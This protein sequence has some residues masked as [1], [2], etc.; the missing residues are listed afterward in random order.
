MNPRAY[1]TTAALLA[2][3]GFVLVAAL[4]L[5]VDA[6]G[7]FGTRLIS[8]AHFPSNLRLMRGWDRV[9]KAI[10]IAERR[11]DQVLFIG[12]SRSQLGIDPDSPALSGMRAY[13]A[14]LAGATLTE[15]IVA[16]D[17]SLAHDPGIKH[18]VWGLSFE[19]F[20]FGIFSWSDYPDSA[21]AGRGMIAGLMR[22]LFAYD[23]VI[24]SW[25]TLLQ[26]RRQVRAQMK[27]N[28]VVTYS[29]ETLEGPAV[30]KMFDSEL[31]GM[32]RNISGKRPQEA[33]DEAH[34]KLKRELSELKSAGVD[35][36]LV[37]MPL[38][39]WR[40]EFFRQIDIEDQSD[41]WKRR[42]AATL[43]ELASAPGSGKLRVFDFAR[44]HP[45]VEQSIFAPPPPG[46]R[47]YY[48]ESSHF[49][50][51]LGEKL[52]ETVFAREQDTGAEPTTEPFGRQIG[53]RAGAISID[54][55]LATAKAALDD[56]EAAHR[57]DVSHV[58]TLIMR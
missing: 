43:D 45:L 39:V 19:E 33:M 22:H 37:I 30:L 35:V 48:L 6:Y 28:G 44:P 31:S 55:D 32:S 12:D 1:I 16:L 11:G 57:D 36:D 56:W 5:A 50:P 52:L 20:P 18:V 54:E 51:W 25:K 34:A 24:S 58:Q 27:R 9:T 14:G 10:E 29:G 47:R 7:V 17:Y 13:N 42:L 38:H 53:H 4:G 46:E 41:A 3:T 40:L 2:L 26:S 8:A 15:Q 21:F 23:R 49:Y